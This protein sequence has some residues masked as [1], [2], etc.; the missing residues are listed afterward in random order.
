MVLVRAGWNTELGRKK[1]DVEVCDRDGDII[2]LLMEKG[3]KPDAELTF[4]E[5]FTLA[6]LTAEIMSDATKGQ[7][8][9]EQR[10]T[11]RADACFAHAQQ[12]HNDR[13]I[14]LA[15]IKLRLGVITQEEY[16]SIVTPLQG[17]Q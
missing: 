3:I 16:T 8:L 15:A 10:E 11:E 1:W 5:A 7:F 17:P 12:L 6:H 9:M 14:A 13:E 4:S 2:R